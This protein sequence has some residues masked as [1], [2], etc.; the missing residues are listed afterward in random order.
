[1]SHDEVRSWPDVQTFGRYDMQQ[2]A[3]K[4]KMLVW[5]L[6]PFYRYVLSISFP[7]AMIH[8]AI[9]IFKER[10]QRRRLK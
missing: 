1:M 7:K 6:R 3:Q 10:N 5:L 8:F 9:S 2:C 4:Y